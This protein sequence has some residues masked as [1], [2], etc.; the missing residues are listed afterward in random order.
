MLQRTRTRKASKK[1]C[2][3]DDVYGVL[4][5]SIH[6]T[7]LF[8]FNHRMCVIML[9]YH[10]HRHIILWFLVGFFFCIRSVYIAFDKASCLRSHTIAAIQSI[11]GLAPPLR[12]RQV[13]QRKIFFFR[14]SLALSFHRIDARAWTSNNCF[15]HHDSHTCTA[16]Y[17]VF[18][19]RRHIEPKCDLK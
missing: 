14:H 11:Y 3:I 13:I 4:L 2:V 17:F 19:R 10:I 18:L 6:C 16:D 12:G 9:Y 1:Q 5:K 15:G 8:E 7:L